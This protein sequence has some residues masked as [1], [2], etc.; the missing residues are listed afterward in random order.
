MLG[1]RGLPATHGGVERAVEELS[2]RLAARGHEV[3]VFCRKS[4]CPERLSRHRGVTLRYLPSVPTKHLEAATHTLLAAL[5]SALRSFDIVHIHS[6]GP[7]LFTPIPRMARKRVVVTVHALDWGRRKW[8]FMAKRALR[9]GAW[10]AIHLADATIAVSKASQRYL[11]AA[12]G[13]SPIYIPNGVNVAPPGDLPDSDPPYLLFL[14]RLVPEKKVDDLV[15]AFK[16][17]PATAR[18]VIAGDGYFSDRHVAMLHR[19]ASGDSR[20]TFAG[21]VY[22]DRKEELLA[23]AAALVNPSELEGH[24]IAVLEALSHGVPV[25]ASDIE[26]H[27]EILE[28]EGAPSHL[29]M[30]FRAG[31]REDLRHKLM[32]AVQLGNDPA[33]RERRRSFVASEYGWDRITEATEAVYRT[34]LPAAAETREASRISC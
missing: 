12:H 32:E 33:S 14:G 27:R 34:L 20:I 18:L 21:A 13:L 17:Q 8:G 22:G 10:T 2:A 6:I 29:G 25:L 11:H 16:D 7:A 24:P 30:V 4:Y 15:S 23:G 28:C 3:T 1:T 26:A 31:D 9:A 5:S 19:L